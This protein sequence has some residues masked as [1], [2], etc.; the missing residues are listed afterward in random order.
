LER[1]RLIGEGEEKDN[2]EFI[3]D[4]YINIKIKKIY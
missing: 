3:D 1:A 4:S 2:N